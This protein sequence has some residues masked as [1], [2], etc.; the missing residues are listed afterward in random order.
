MTAPTTVTP[1]ELQRFVSR[2]LEALPTPTDVADEVAEHLVGAN[3][4]GHDSHGVIR[5]PQ[6]MEMAAAGTL[7][8]GAR[9]RL[10]DDRGAIA[11]VSGERGFGQLAGRYAID[12]G[13]W[14]A[15]EHGVAA[16]ALRR[17]THLGRLGAYMERAADAGCVAICCVGGFGAG[18]MAVPYGGAGH[19]YGANPIAAGFPTPDGDPVLLD[20]ATTRIAGG[21]V[22][23]AAAAGTQ[24]PAG[25]IVDAQG[26]PTTDPH[27]FLAGGALLPFGEHKGYGLA[28][29]AELLGQ[30]LTGADATA[31]DGVDDPVF[32]RTGGLF[33]VV[34]AGA[35]RD[36]EQT[37]AAAGRLVRR[38]REIPPAPGFDRVRTPGEPEAATRAD[39][40]ARGIDLPEETW[41]ELRAAA[42]R[43][44]LPDDVLPP[45]LRTEEI[46]DA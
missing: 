13:I 23:V 28:V 37:V 35:F 30:A 9:P 43:A 21:K 12:E 40:R 36:A 45:L 17:C 11:T 18:H 5:A 19:A 7:V 31:P 26:R 33:L 3:L 46:D 24:L 1:E 32:G 29:L 39:R 44:A 10:E 20:F 4:V 41:A 2:L 22:L 15:R 38:L 16:V 6:Y 27:A 8:P 42:A 34:D 25:C 14:R